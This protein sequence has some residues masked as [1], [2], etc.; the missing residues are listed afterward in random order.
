MKLTA[1]RRKESSDFTPF[2]AD[3]QAPGGTIGRCPGNAMVL[4]SANDDICRLQAVVRISNNDCYLLNMSDMTP[5]SVNGQP[6]LPRS[7]VLLHVGD[8]VAI[9]SY[10]LQSE[11]DRA[12]ANGNIDPAPTAVEDDPWADPPSA[13]AAAPY[14]VPAAAVAT[15]AAVALPLETRSVPDAATVFPASHGL[16]DEPAPA[17]QPVE[18]DT[19]DPLLPTPAEDEPPVDIFSD[20]LG[21]GTLPVGSVPDVSAHPFD[22]ASDARLNPVN[23]LDQHVPTDLDAHR[24]RDPLAAFDSREASDS[25][26]IFTDDTP[27]TLRHQDALTG[28]RD[29]AIGGTLTPVASDTAGG[30]PDRTKEFGGYMRPAAVQHDDRDTP[31]ATGFA[32]TTQDDKPRR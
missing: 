11:D 22:L 32:P 29:N 16:P 2:S 12:A 17:H 8:E 28:Y 9:G 26:H 24:P 15:A 4:P 1:I 19:T 6:V 3:F 10:V 20:L 23:P 21:P 27:T 18:P 7:E 31:R 13:P 5:V 30:N 25:H 14:A